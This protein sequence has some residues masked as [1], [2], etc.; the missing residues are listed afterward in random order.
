MFDYSDGDRH[1]LAMHYTPHVDLAF[2]SAEHIMRD[3]EGGWLLRYMHANGASMF[4]LVVYLHI[5]R[6]LYYASYSSPRELVW[7]MGYILLLMIITA[8][9]GYV[10]LGVK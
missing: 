3:V 9:I 5:F 8:F 4:F 6:G 1:L 10:L 2:L 7:C